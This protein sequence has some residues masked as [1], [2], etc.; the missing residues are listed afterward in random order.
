MHFDA[1]VIGGGINGL[2]TAYHLTR[3]GVGSIAVVERFAIGNDRG[4]SHGVSRITRSTYAHADY[5]RLM[6]HVHS[7][8]WP[9]LERDLNRTLIHRTPG[10]FFGPQGQMFQDYR[11]AVLSTGANVEPLLADD[12]RRRFP[13]FTFADSKEVLLDHTAGLIAASDV[14]DGLKTW[15][16]SRSVVIFENTRV[17]AVDRSDSTI[18]VST[19]REPITTGR[20]AIAAGAWISDFVPELRPRLTVVRQTVGYFRLSGSVEQFRC[21]NFPVWCYLHDSPARFF[22]GLPEFGPVG[23]GIKYARHRTQD[24]AD[25]PEDESV[26]PANEIEILRQFASEQFVAPIEA[27]VRVEHCLYTNTVDE[28]FIIDFH[29][30]D[31]RIVFAS[32]C[33]GHGFK[34]GPLTGRA[35]AEMLVEGEVKVEAFRKVQSRFQRS[36]SRRG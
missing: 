19:D 24:S 8:E 28:D 9:R 23:G 27:T 15:L 34:F 2:C 16:Q 33:S 18:S 7:E 14:I 25:D 22:Y 1:V 12:A 3:L 26:D 13:Q 36:A 31:R 6:Q 21:G 10:C 30:T 35:L 29:P 32:A 20:L 11:D 4:S 17:V 5:V